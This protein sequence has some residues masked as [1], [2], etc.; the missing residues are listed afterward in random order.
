MR[1][2]KYLS[3]ETIEVNLALV[4]L[5]LVPLQGGSVKLTDGKGPPRV[6]KS[7]GD[8]LVAVGDLFDA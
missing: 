7:V 5:S 8:A 6:F 1:K 2:P 4:G 3:G